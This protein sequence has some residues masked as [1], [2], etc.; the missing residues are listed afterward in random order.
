[1]AQDTT[2]SPAP[3][4]RVQPG[5]LAEFKALC[6]RM[7]QKTSTEP[8]ALYC[9][10]CFDGD[11]AF[12]REAFEDADAWLAHLGNIGDIFGEMLKVA[13]ITRLEFH[14]SD[15][16]LAKVR[17]ALADMGMQAQLFTLEGGFRRSAAATSV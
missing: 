4:F 5:K 9:G 2:I 14:G 3:Y 7:V 8:G 1:M 11:Q 16:E 17:K 6:E 13:E 12:S 10:F 15:A